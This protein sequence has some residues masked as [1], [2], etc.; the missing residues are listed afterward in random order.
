MLAFLVV[1]GLNLN[2]VT[3]VTL[4]TFQRSEEKQVGEGEGRGTVAEGGGEMNRTELIKCVPGRICHS[5]VSQGDKWNGKL[6][7]LSSVQTDATY[8][9]FKK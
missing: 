3:L 5:R 2:A 7:K 1:P 9:H 8:R 6:F 4:S